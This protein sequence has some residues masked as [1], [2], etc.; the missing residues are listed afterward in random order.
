M[1]GTAFRLFENRTAEDKC[2]ALGGLRDVRHDS[3][4]CDCL[5]FKEIQPHSPWMQVQLHFFFEHVFST[6]L[7][8]MCC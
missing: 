5:K 4:T 1:R 2:E 6:C 7:Y 8:I 3:L